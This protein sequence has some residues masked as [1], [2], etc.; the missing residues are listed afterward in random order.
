MVDISKRRFLFLSAISPILFHFPA[1]AAQKTILKPNILYPR[2]IE[3]LQASFTTEMIANKHYLSYTS[4]ALI[5]NYPNIAYLFHSFSY[6]EKI[7]ADNYKRILRSLG[8]PA[9]MLQFK[10]IVRDTKSNLRQA[11]KNELEKIQTTY[12]EF[13]LKLETEAY[14]EAIINCMY[15]WKSH[16]QHEKTV[17][18]IAKYSGI[19]FSSVS[20]KIEGLNPNYYICRI[21]GSTID[22][23]PRSPCVICNRSQSN[24]QQIE[25]QT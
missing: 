2:T 11:A 20:K 17:K 18:K 1:L 13:I 21:C 16:E 25:R 23:T 3:V 24:Y 14:E 7:H 9:Q 4:K 8:H 22:E 15:S 10:I 19:F 5:D 12:P 6:S